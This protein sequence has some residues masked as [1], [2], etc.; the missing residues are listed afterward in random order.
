MNFNRP[1]LFLYYLF[2][3]FATFNI[4]LAK[5]YISEV[6]LSGVKVLHLERN[7]SPFSIDLPEGW[8]TDVNGVNGVTDFLKNAKLG[9]NISINAYKREEGQGFIIDGVV[10]KSDEKEDVLLE[11]SYQRDMAYYQNLV[12]GGQVK[13]ITQTKFILDG[14]PAYRIQVYHDL[15]SNGGGFIDFIS[16]YTKK[17]LYDIKIYTLDGNTELEDKIIKTIKLMR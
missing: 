9:A 4:S 1:L 16:C 6:C 12:R 14:L 11:K 13:L 15:K 17:Y 2:L 3:I 5:E 10:Y 7:Q 8:I